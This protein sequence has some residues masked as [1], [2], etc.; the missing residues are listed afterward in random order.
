MLYVATLMLVFAVGKLS[1][2][3]TVALHGLQFYAYH[4]VPPEERALGHRYE[5]DVWI[6]VEGRA[7]FSDRV[8][9]TVDYG[10]LGKLIVEQST[11]AQYKTI[12]RL[13]QVICD[14]VLK[15][16]PSAKE[17]R[18]ALRKHMPPAPI[19]VRSSEVEITVS[20][21]ADV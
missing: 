8:E 12:E 2:M 11:S 21:E 16:F 7:N 15:E 9:D 19:I 1:S 18:L 5:V 6:S 4:G 10:E 20:R 13:A 3:F 17:V 14:R